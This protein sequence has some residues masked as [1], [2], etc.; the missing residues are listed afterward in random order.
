MSDYVY[1]DV[2]GKEINRVTKGRGRLK[3]GAVKNEKDGNYYITNAIP[4]EKKCCN[5]NNG[6]CCNG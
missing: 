2:N 5:P 3:K 6:N 1:T 4:S